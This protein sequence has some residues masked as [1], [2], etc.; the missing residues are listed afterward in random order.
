MLLRHRNRKL[1]RYGAIS[2]ASLT[3]QLRFQHNPGIRIETVFDATDT[4]CKKCIPPII[5]AGKLVL[6]MDRN[7]LGY[8]PKHA[9]LEIQAIHVPLTCSRCAF[10]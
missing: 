9:A 5:Y 6:F 8:L 2:I 10:C 7:R 1:M 4:I 3:D